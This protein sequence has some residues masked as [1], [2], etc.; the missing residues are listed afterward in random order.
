MIPVFEICGWL[1][2]YM[3]QTGFAWSQKRNVQI[4]FSN[5]KKN[6]LQDAW[7]IIIIIEAQ[8]AISKKKMS[9]SGNIFRH[10][11]LGLFKTMTTIS[12]EDF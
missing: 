11:L 5:I 7:L 9:H 12:S 2:V 1:P 6:D 3:I 8:L 10:I 4:N